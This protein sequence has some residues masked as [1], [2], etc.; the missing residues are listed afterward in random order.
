MAKKKMDCPM[1]KGSPCHC[2][3]LAWLLLILGVLFLL[4]DFGVWHFW[5]ISGWAVAFLLAGLCMLCC[6]KKC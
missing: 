3:P 6:K 1:C 2:S 4:R 5:D